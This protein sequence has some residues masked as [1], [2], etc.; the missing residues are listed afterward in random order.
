MNRQENKQARKETKRQKMILAA[1]K[2]IN[3]P[4][5]PSQSSH[6]ALISIQKLFYKEKEASGNSTGFTLTL[7][8]RHTYADIH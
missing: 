3:Y 4:S 8:V 5:H 2:Y 7:K 6:H 1:F